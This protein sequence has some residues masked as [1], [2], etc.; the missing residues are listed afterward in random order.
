VE[1]SLHEISPGTE[2]SRAASAGERLTVWYMERWI[3]LSSCGRKNS[4]F[5]WEKEV[6]QS[7]RGAVL[8]GPI[9]S[10]LL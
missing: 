2:T 1:F 7:C 6:M 5:P 8:N 3:S 10:V 4:E 9:P